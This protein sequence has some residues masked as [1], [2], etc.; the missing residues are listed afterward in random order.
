MNPCDFLTRH[1]Q[2]SQRIVFTEIGF[3]GKGESGQV[4]Q[5]PDRLR[6]Q[7][8]PLKGFLVKGDIPQATDSLPQTMK[9]QA[10]PFCQ[11]LGFS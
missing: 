2:E 4:I 6:R 3:G 9:L 7:V 1:R 10:L 11:G 8:V 5:C